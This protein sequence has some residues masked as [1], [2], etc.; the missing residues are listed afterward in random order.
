MNLL[1]N[2]VMCSDFQWLDCRVSITINLETRSNWNKTGPLA[3]E[4]HALCQ[5]KTDSSKWQM[6]YGGQ[7]GTHTESEER[8]KRVQDNV[9]QKHQIFSQKHRGQ[10]GKDRN[11]QTQT[12]GPPLPLRY[13]RLTIPVL[14]NVVQ[15]S[16]LKL[17]PICSRKLSGVTT[18]IRCSRLSWEL[19]SWI[20][21]QWPVHLSWFS[22]QTIN[23]WRAGAGLHTLQIPPGPRQG[24]SPHC[25]CSKHACKIN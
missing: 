21:P 24:I 9:P 19:I 12:Q 17:N 1:M 15:T 7:P 5:P 13:L 20:L 16:R 18:C 8:K 22:S 2:E 11:L 23:F 25:R 6:W 3:P 4:R 10:W 14:F